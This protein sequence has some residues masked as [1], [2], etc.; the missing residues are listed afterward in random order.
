MVSLDGRL[1]HANPDDE[2]ELDLLFQSSVSV[3]SC[4]SLAA[5]Y[6]L[7]HLKPLELGVIQIQ[8]LV[9]PCSTMRGAERLRF[10]P[11]FKDRTAFPDRVRSIEGV[12]LGLG[13][14]EKVKLYEARYLVEMTVARHPDLLESCFGSLGYSETVHGDK[15][16]VVS[17]SRWRDGHIARSRRE[18]AIR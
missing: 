18:I 4:R 2:D 9:V 5:P 11:R 15:H 10:G 6:R 13:A 14:F 16:S 1:H 12:I 17:Y 8:R 3:A 7:A